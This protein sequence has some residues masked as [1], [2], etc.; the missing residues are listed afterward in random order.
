[1]VRIPREGNK[2]R[3]TNTTLRMACTFP[4]IS[5]PFTLMNDDFYITQ[6]VQRI[7]TLN[8]GT[9]RNVIHSYTR[10][11]FGE[12][13][14]TR[15]MKRTLKHLESLGYQDPLSYE[16]HTPLVVHKATMLTALNHGPYQ[17]RTIYGNLHGT[18][19]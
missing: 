4:E 8:L 10:Q 3:H 17:R 2:H 1:L 15:G 16:T 5:D 12:A 7:P 13:S 14:Y 18:K 9:V 11:G 19:G 6:P